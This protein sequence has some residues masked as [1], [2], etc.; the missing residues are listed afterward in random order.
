MNFIQMCLAGSASED[1]IDRFVDQWHDGKAGKG[2]NYT[3][4]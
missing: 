3:S 1:E 2:K 4:S